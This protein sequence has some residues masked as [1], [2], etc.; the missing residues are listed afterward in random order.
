MAG[1]PSAQL[2]RDE[3]GALP[4]ALGLPGNGQDGADGKDGDGHAVREQDAS[5]LRS[6]PTPVKEPLKAPHT[7]PP[8][9]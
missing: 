4:A 9:S 1:R 7:P 2:L 6:V 3:D 8:S 5:R